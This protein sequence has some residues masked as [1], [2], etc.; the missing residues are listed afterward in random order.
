MDALSGMLLG[1][2]A[3]ALALVA[4]LT[5]ILRQRLQPF[6]I[7]QPWLIVIIIV[8]FGQLCLLGVQWF[9]GRL[10]ESLSYW[11]STLT[12]ALIWPWLAAGLNRYRRQ[13]TS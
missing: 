2:N 13:W 8:G 10:P 9:I 6:P 12:S 3:L 1:Q 4:F 5:K 11:F 7:W